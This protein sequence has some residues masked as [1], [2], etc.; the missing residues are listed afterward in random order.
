[1]D[2][3]MDRLKIDARRKK[4]LEILEHEGQVRVDQ[5]SLALNATMVTIRTDLAALEQNGYLS[6][7]PG[8]AVQTAKNYFNMDLRRRN[9]RNI[10]FKKAIAAAAAERVRDGE[11]LMLNSG[12]TTFLTAVELKSRKN[13]NIVTNSIS[14]A[15]EL[16]SHPTFRV[17]LLGG[18]INT[19]YSFLYGNDAA[20]QLSKY[21][22]DKAILSVDG[23]CSGAGLTTH[24]AEEA[25]ID[26]MMMDRSH[27][28]MIVADYTKLGKESFFNIGSF[29][30]DLT[31]VTNDC[32]DEQQAAEI[33]ALGIEVVK[34]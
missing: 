22:A 3:N 14:V 12:T 27:Q 33:K 34:A 28:T 11:T 30:G 29:S 21:K 16:G 6:R 13:L 1:M 25:L 18:E 5:L 10:Q 24:H 19:Q 31:W 23:I 8:G 26:R 7:V 2:K 32:V 20:V 9:Q 4:I 17:I 15:I